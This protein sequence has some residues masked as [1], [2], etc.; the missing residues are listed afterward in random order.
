[1]YRNAAAALIAIILP[2][3]SDQGLVHV[4]KASLRVLDATDRSI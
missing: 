1:M 2:G 4:L 3:Y